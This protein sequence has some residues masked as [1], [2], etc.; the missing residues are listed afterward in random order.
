MKTT[1]NAAGQPAGTG[2]VRAQDLA[3]V[4]AQTRYVFESE[5][6]AGQALDYLQAVLASLPPHPAFEEIIQEGDTLV[7]TACGT[8]SMTAVVLADPPPDQ[9]AHAGAGSREAGN[10]SEQ[11]VIERTP[12]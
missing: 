5:P 4:I 6:A 2:N 7:C 12:S 10:A 3:A 11:L 9:R 8:T 1:Q